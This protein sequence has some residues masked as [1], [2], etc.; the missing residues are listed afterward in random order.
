MRNLWFNPGAGGWFL[1]VGFLFLVSGSWLAVAGC[2]FLGLR[3][4]VAGFLFSA[5]GLWLL[6]AGG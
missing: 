5:N 4:L 1:D 3:P 6:V 2:W